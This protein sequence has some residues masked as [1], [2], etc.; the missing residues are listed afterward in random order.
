MARFGSKLMLIFTALLFF[1]ALGGV[2]FAANNAT[3]V[4][5]PIV[6]PSHVTAYLNS[7]STVNFTITLYNGTAGKTCLAVGNSGQLIQTGIHATLSPSLGV[8]PFNG[9][10]AINVSSSAA[11]GNYTV[12][13]GTACAD[14]SSHGIAVVYLVVLNQLRPTTTIASTS[15]ITPTTTTSA[16]ATTTAPYTSPPVTTF[17]T[18]LAA[19]VIVVIIII[20]VL[21][22]LWWYIKHR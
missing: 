22:T 21:L 1:S 19:I 14:P 9:T 10:M 17:N 20:I 15:S 4:A 5:F 13:L 3:G 12:Q 8:P 11:P 6:R 18:A 2:S 7:V 16:A